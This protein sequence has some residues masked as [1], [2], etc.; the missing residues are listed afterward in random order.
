MKND[1]LLDGKLDDWFYRVKA[2]RPR[3]EPLAYEPVK[4]WVW[5][6]GLMNPLDPEPWHAQ[7][8]GLPTAK[9][10]PKAPRRS[11]AA[12]K[13]TFECGLDAEGRL[14][15]Q[16]EHWGGK[17]PYLNLYFHLPGRI[18]YVRYGTDRYLWRPPVAVFELTLDKRGRVVRRENYG[19]LA[20]WP[21]REPLTAAD[22]KALKKA[23][24]PNISHYRVNFGWD[25][26]RLVKSDDGVFYDYEDGEL[27][28]IWREGV[29]GRPEVRWIKGRT[30]WPFPLPPR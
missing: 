24:P 15:V 30:P 3:L 19:N 2:L 16:I 5:L 12:R 9:L 28:R 25:G 1:D 20:T 7:R 6:K 13:G 26:D 29:K 23:P 18:R 17:E 11:L 22:V 21:D 14:C 4:R 27:V 8:A 10:L